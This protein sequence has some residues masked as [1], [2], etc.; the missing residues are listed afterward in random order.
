[1]TY[2]ER[3]KLSQTIEKLSRLTEARG[4]TQAEALMA[5]EKI[6]VLR[7]RL[8]PRPTGVYVESW[9]GVPA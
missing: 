8:Y 3:L 2:A 1:M 7:D 9:V 5:R 6:V 4:A